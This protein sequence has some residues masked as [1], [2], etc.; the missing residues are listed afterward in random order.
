MV[1]ARMV[2]ASAGAAR[3]VRVGAPPPRAT[4][5]TGGR[6]AASGIHARLIATGYTGSFPVAAVAFALG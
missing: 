6:A 5:G 2:F 4:R 3:I 1:V